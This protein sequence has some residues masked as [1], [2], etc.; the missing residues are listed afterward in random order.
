MMRTLRTTPKMALGL[1]GGGAALGVGA[2]ALWFGGA[3]PA[4]AD[5]PP[6]GRYQLV[7]SRYE[8]YDGTFLV[9]TATGDTWRFK[10][11]GPRGSWIEIRR[12]AP[13]APN[14]PQQPR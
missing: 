5:T 12:G 11:D 13:E 3:R 10:V 9:D 8:G 2:L 4:S 7:H 1:L 6:T 14:E